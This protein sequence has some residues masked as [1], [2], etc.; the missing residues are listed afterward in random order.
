[1]ELVEVSVLVRKIGCCGMTID[2]TGSISF[3]LGLLGW[4]H[5][6]IAFVSP[7]SLRSFKFAEVSISSGCS[8]SVFFLVYFFPDFLIGVGG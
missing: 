6:Y 3:S 1:M 4:V 7:L 5:S 2:D 8:L